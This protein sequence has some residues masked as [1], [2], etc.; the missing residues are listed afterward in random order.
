MGSR[1]W[2]GDPARQE[3]DAHMTGSSHFTPLL[4]ILSA[5]AQST[6]QQ[7]SSSGETVQAAP[8]TDQSAVAGR[9]LTALADEY[10]KELITT[11]PL[12]GVFFGV[13]ETPNDRLGDNSI[14]ATRRWEKKQDRLRERLAQINP[15]P[16]QGHP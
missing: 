12:Y 14:A 8:A 11:F 1:L 6:S 13:P 10:W 16:L 5:C 9:Q 7:G 2:R 15:E 3:S 4:L